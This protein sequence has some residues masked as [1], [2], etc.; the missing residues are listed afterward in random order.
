MKTRLLKKLRAEAKEKYIVTLDESDVH[1]FPYD[2]R[3]LYEGAYGSYRYV[4]QK[5]FRDKEQAIAY[6]D[7]C[8]REYILCKIYEMKGKVFVE[9]KL[10]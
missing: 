9:N 4:L 3:R 7:K 5:Y 10:Y 2:V 6:C 1:N 8:R